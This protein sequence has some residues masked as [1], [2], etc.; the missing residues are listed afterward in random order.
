VHK[1]RPVSLVIHG[2]CR[3]ADVR[4][5]WAARFLGIPFQPFPAEW[6]KY[7]LAA[8]PIRNRQMLVEGKPDL[9]MAFHD[10]LKNS[11]GTRD[12]LARADKASI[13]ARHYS[14]ERDTW[15]GWQRPLPLPKQPN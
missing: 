10:N 2:A 6:K 8:G 4:G 12:M 15:S 9:V 13:E 11:K 14:H 5:E 1:E 7:G 3:G